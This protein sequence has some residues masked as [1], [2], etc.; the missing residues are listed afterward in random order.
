VRRASTCRCSIARCL[1]SVCGAGRSCGRWPGR[2]RRAGSAPAGSSTASRGGAA[3]AD[4]GAPQGTRSSQQRRR[5][6]SVEDYFFPGRLVA[7]D[8]GLG[9]YTLY[10]HSTRSPSQRRP[11][12]SRPADRHGRSDRKGDGP[13]STF[14]RPARQRR[15]DR[16]RSS[17]FVW[18]ISGLSSL[19]PLRRLRDFA[20]GR[21][22]AALLPSARLGLRGRSSAALCRCS[23]GPVSRGTLL[24][25]HAHLGAGGDRVAAVAAPSIMR[26]MPTPGMRA[27]CAIRCT[28][29]A[30]SHAKIFSNAAA[31]RSRP[32]SRRSRR[33]TRRPARARQ[34]RTHGAA[35]D[36]IGRATA[37]GFGCRRDRRQRARP[38]SSGQAQ[39]SAVRHS[40]RGIASA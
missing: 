4:Y 10:F 40:A 24:G 35:R 25:G 22:P 38:I 9:L 26:S 12:G 32:A 7:L 37:S 33:R 28:R 19:R 5:V 16:P 30:A 1:P 8:H 27:C 3:G 23:S 29:G 11:G 39:A 31:A 21:L 2:S 17:L 36:L 34:D 15:V 18:P 6:A 20:R 13:A 14:R